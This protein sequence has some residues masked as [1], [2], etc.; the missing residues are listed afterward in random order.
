LYKRCIVLVAD[1]ARADLMKRLLD[2]GELPNIKK[3][4]TDRGCFR[5]AMT[6]FPS[7][8]GPAHIPFVSGIHPGTANVPGY[9]W[10]SRSTHD[11]KRRSIYRH[12][13]LNSPRGLFLGSDMDEEK[14]TS[15]FEHFDNP[16][17]VLEPV[18]YCRTQDL[19]KIIV[20]RLFYVVRAHKTD[21]WG[22][23]DK[24]VERNV[25]R[26]IKSDSEC[27]I[28]TF[29]GIDEYS[30]LY[31]PFDERTLGAYRNIDSAV[32]HIV[33][34]LQEKKI[35]DET[36]MAVV[37]D[38]G[39]S[40]T[41]VHIP[42]VDI[43]REHGFAPHFYP[44]LYRKSC[45]CAVMESG[46]AMAQLYFKRGQRWGDH[47]KYEEMVAD[48]RVGKLLKSLVHTK[49]MSFAAARSNDGIVFVGRK[50]TLFAAQNDGGYDVRVEG[51]S[52]LPEHPT[53]HFGQTELF[54]KTFYSTYP[55][56]VNQLFLLFSSERSGDLV[57]SS[58]PTYDLRL[59]YEDPEHH[60]S[61]GSL[62]REHMHVPLAFSVPIRDEYVYNYDI[63][64]TILA[65]AG[66]ET[67]KPF[68]GRL[69]NVD[70][71]FLANPDGTVAAGTGKEAG[72]ENSGGKWLSIAITAGII[73]MG[74]IITAIFADKINSFGQGLMQTYGQTWVDVIL[75]LLTA[76]SSTPL[77]FPIWGYV[78]V[79]VAMGYNV[80]HLAAVMAVG[81][82]T[83]SFV[84]FLLGRYFGK[85]AWVKKK[86]PKLREHPW[87]KG[88][89]RWMVTL[90]LF[91]GT[92]SPLPCDVFYAACG[93]KRYPPMLFWVTMIAARFVRYIYL[94]YGFDLFHNLM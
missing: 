33:E 18:D 60:S 4:I 43:V 78:L 28:A 19:N 87:A 89:S 11:S 90:F 40:A 20:R 49:G 13:S 51:E 27:V 52:P 45:D 31:D 65:L 94:G 75:F 70:N 73:I 1:G 80:I 14:S 79:G 8:T 23:I 71:G 10:L 83:G 44:K 2:Q 15:L 64:P 58:D 26:R 41:T 50:G 92:A 34:V 30:H 62:H 46:N 69:L 16:A 36:I 77:A 32:G 12:R 39:L 93:A 42:V 68:D 37:S 76:I 3:H 59:Q 7:T 72:E 5:T 35:Y 9:R 25:I 84:T 47:W 86:F 29:F 61:H 38:H 56:A 6:V 55:D 57:L 81:S 67:A 91:L 54:E 74:M 17:S 53:G 88:R 63:V 24:M 21:D 82:A 85:S 48:E 22:P 66:K